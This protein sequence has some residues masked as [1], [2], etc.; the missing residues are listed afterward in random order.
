MRPNISN[1]TESICLL[2]STVP[3]TKQTADLFVGLKIAIKAILYSE[4]NYFQSVSILTY[5]L[6]Q[7][8]DVNNLSF[9]DAPTHVNIH[10]CIWKYTQ[11]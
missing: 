2:S 7:H 1:K 4:K 6:Q 10:M 9:F 8:C 3:S 11:L 5:N